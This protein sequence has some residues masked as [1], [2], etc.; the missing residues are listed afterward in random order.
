MKQVLQYRRSGTTSVVDVP[1]PLAP[2]D[3]AL[4]RT[5]WSLI[6]PGT[7]RMLVEGSGANLLNTAVQRPDL[8]RQVVDKA[9]REGIVDTVQAVRSRLDVAIPLGYSCAGTVLELNGAVPGIGV[10]DRVACAGSGFANHAEFVGVPRNLL[11]RVPDAVSLEDAAFVTVGAIALH[12]MRIAE[13]RVG[14]TCVVIGLGLVGQL[15]V[16]LL[17]AGGCR[18]FGVDVAEDRT[19]LARSLGAD[20][21][22]LRSDPSLEQQVRDLTRGRG[23][24]AVLI[25]AATSSSDPVELAP[26]IV[27]DRAVVVAV[28]MVGLN[29][30]RNAY[31]EKE[32][33]LRVSRSY[34]PG[35]HDRRY[36][37][38]GVDY[39]IG[40]VR[41]TEQRNMEAF[42]NLVSQGSVRPVRLI[43]HRFPIED[44][45]RAY[46]VVTGE[47]GEPSLGILLSYPAVEGA[48]SH[49]VPS[50]SV[51]SPSVESRRLRLGVVGAG[52]FARAV[53]LPALRRLSDRVELRAVATA[54]GP[55]AQQTMARFGFDYASVDWRDVV[56]D[57]QLDAVVVATRHDLHAEVAGEALRAGRSVLLEKP[58]ALDDEQLSH[59]LATWEANPRLLQ[60]GFNRRFSPTIRQLQSVYAGRRDPLVLQY[61]VNAGP[62]APGSWVVDP[63]QGGGRLV[64]EVCHMVDTL[65]FLT[66]APVERVWAQALPRPP[67]PTADD[68]V[69]T[70]SFADGS[71]GTIVYAA[72]GDRAMPKERLEVF[73][74]GVSAVLDDFVSLSVFDQGRQRR[75]GR[76]RTQDKG[77]TA[78]L[79]A[80]VDAAMRGG[81]SPI[82][83]LDAAH[84]TR[85][86][87][88]A[89]VSAGSGEP[90]TIGR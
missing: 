2:L 15:T 29:V 52:S 1:A 12:G 23:A 58:M 34:G 27:R 33:E 61:R 49:R 4:V 28:G 48:P 32:L 74:G 30:P 51:P 5:A 63:N 18:V 17:K 90:V 43:T 76:W 13:C 37:Q 9:R 89:A 73:G 72:G 79:S 31:Y 36:E 80:F 7:E 38:E 56:H 59:L 44:A 16:Q 68:V 45:E 3:G 55:S 67:R 88:A 70:L 75:P 50:P 40:Y 84:V 77:H 71:I 86:T 26:R 41:W 6:S 14:D 42:L 54:S 85:V 53:L 60:V 81:P 65:F 21:A 46:Q 69:L 24:D 20:G 82:H 64:G 25:T 78:E 19:E 47:A 66:G 83:P 62:V 39:P 10:G 22:C 57:P 11:V 8:V 35:R 87:F